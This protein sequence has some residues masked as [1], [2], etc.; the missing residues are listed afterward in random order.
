MTIEQFPKAAMALSAVLL[1]FL[2]LVAV[3]ASTR[4]FRIHNN[5]RMPPRYWS[6]APDQR[7]RHQPCCCCSLQHRHG[8]SQHQH[9]QLYGCRRIRHGH[10]RLANK[11]AAF[12]PAADLAPDTMYNATITT[13]ARDVSGTPLA[14]PFNFSFTTR[15]TNDTSPPDIVAINVAAGATCVALDQKISVTFD[16]QMDSL[17]INPSTF[18]IRRRG[19]RSD[20]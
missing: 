17:T 13:A 3:A 7:R 4:Q 2:F 12:K 6:C 18:F 10:L 5:S 15:T 14:A 20:V 9:R 19:R 16:E 11:I 1:F 8:P